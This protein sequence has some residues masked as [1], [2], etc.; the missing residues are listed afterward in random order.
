LKYLRKYKRSYGKYK[1]YYRLYKKLVKSLKCRRPT[2][3]NHV[4]RFLRFKT[5]YVLRYRFL[6]V[7]RKITHKGLKKCVKRVV[8]KLIKKVKRAVRKITHKVYI[9]IK[10]I[11]LTKRT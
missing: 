7:F 9:F 8:K 1:K 2:I 6:R 3:C 4:P 5:V 10:R 11:I